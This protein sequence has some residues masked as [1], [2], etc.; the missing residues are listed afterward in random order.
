MLITNFKLFATHHQPQ[1]HSTLICLV[2]VGTNDERPH[3]SHGLQ[4]DYLQLLKCFLA[5]RQGMLTDHLAY[6]HQLQW[7]IATKHT[8]NTNGRQQVFCFSKDL[9]PQLLKPLNEHDNPH[10]PLYPCRSNISSFHTNLFQSKKKSPQSMK[11][12]TQVVQEISFMP[13]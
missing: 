8:C 2:F 1:L 10:S 3:R 12:Y 5:Y 6:V 11:A 7:H 4:L 13:I 9:P